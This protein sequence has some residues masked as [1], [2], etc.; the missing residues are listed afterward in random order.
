[1]KK[2]I[3]LLSVLSLILSIS[4]L[5]FS[6]YDISMEIR[7]YIFNE[8]GQN[9]EVTIIPNNKTKKGDVYIKVINPRFPS[10][11]KNIRMILLSIG[12][13]LEQS[14]SYQIYLGIIM[15]DINNNLYAISSENCRKAYIAKTT[16][17]GY[18]IIER[19]LKKLK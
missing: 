12:K 19:N 1:M 7:N 15:V 11:D 9:T 6:E 8:T 4:Y 5:A 14:I 13:L 18:S 10:K 16:E 3:L 2:T 17:E